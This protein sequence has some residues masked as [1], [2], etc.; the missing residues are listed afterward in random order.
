MT[1][2]QV[3][4]PLVVALTGV[5]GVVASRKTERANR[6]KRDAETASIWA[7]TASDTAKSWQMSN[8]LKDKTIRELRAVIKVLQAELTKQKDDN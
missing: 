8:K 4:P 3:V 1:W 7:D 6:P 5:A 2:W